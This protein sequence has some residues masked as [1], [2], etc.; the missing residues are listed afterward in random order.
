M[1]DYEKVTTFC[2]EITNDSK[3]PYSLK[4]LIGISEETKNILLDVIRKYQK[5]HTHKESGY[6]ESELIRRFLQ[7]TSFIQKKFVEIEGP[8]YVYQMSSNKYPHIFYVFG[9]YHEK[10]SECG[11][12]P[13]FFKWINDTVVNS[14]VFIDIYLE[15]SYQYKKYFSVDDEDLEDSHMTDVYREF[16]QCNRKSNANYCQTMRFHYT[17][18]RLIFET[19]DQKWGSEYDDTEE[20]YQGDEMDIDIRL[21]RINL[22]IDFIINPRSFVHKRI[23]KQFNAIKDEKIKNTIEKEF[24]ACLG[25]YKKRI[26]HLIPKEPDDHKAQKVLWAFEDY[27]ECLMITI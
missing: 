4:N 17:D 16:R 13:R 15:L 9:D 2:S 18:M 1:G 12:I 6:I 14:P 8:Y 10:R 20:I 23:E 27:K 26:R 21:V 3:Y 24:R 22:Y 19:M 7:P 25:K 11:N 5:L